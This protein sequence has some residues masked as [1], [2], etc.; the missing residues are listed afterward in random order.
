MILKSF[1][2]PLS[3]RIFS[4]RAERVEYRGTLKVVNSLIERLK[5]LTHYPQ[6][7]M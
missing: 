3:D 1:A 7:L 4:D 2:I 6:L 5:L